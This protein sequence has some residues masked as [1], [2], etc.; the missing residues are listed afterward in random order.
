MDQAL[1]IAKQTSQGMVE[2]SN[3]QSDGYVHHIPNCGNNEI[4]QGR[5]KNLIELSSRVSD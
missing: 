5:W 3:N 4:L 2:S 1:A